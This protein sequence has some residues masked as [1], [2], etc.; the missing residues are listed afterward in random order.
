MDPEGR[1]EVG[2]TEAQE[3]GQKIWLRVG[4]MTDGNTGP[5]NSAEKLAGEWPGG[6]ECRE[7][8]KIEETSIMKRAHFVPGAASVKPRD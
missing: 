2:K 6:W 4:R 7:T 8:S 3:L 1:W 5:H